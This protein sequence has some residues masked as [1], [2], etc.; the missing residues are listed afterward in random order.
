MRPCCWIA[1]GSVNGQI[2]AYFSWPG[3][4]G[5]GALLTQAAGLDS[6]M[7]MANWSPLVLNLLYALPLLV[8]FRWATDDTRLQWV[9]RLFPAL[10]RFWTLPAVHLSGGQKQMLATARAIRR[11]E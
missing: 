9:L 3:F 6:P 4:F 5:L 8:I 1:D 7:S 10:K 11:D 2:D